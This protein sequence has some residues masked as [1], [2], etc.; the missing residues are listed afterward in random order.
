[1]CAIIS[2]HYEDSVPAGMESHSYLPEYIT[3]VYQDRQRRQPL[4]SLVG[5]KRES[6]LIVVMEFSQQCKTRFP[7]LLRRKTPFSIHE[8]TYTLTLKFIGECRNFLP[9]G[10]ATWVANISQPLS[11]PRITSLSSNRCLIQVH[12]KP[13]TCL[14][15]EIWQDHSLKEEVCNTLWQGLTWVLI[16]MGRNEET[17]HI[18]AHKIGWFSSQKPPSFIAAA[19]VETYEL[20]WKM[21]LLVLMGATTLHSFNYT[22]SC[23]V[24]CEMT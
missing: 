3:M 17:L 19:G 16:E 1:M 7:S 11:P 21:L 18:W 13:R 8:H 12:T 22:M 6:N 4:P 14:V 24:S 10:N 23:F 2:G 20:I 15:Y 9:W 5:D